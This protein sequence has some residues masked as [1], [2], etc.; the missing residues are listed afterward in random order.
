MPMPTPVAYLVLLD[1]KTAGANYGPLSTQ[2]Q[3]SAKWW[4]YMST[5]WIVLRYDTLVELNNLLVPLIFTN[6]RMLILPA[7]RPAGGWLPADAWQWITQNVP[8]EW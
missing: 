5:V 8:S 1:L 4:H 6:D 3:A 7:K 2:L